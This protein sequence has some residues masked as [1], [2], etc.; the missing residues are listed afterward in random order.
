MISL[1][2]AHSRLYDSVLVATTEKESRLLFDYA[3]HVRVAVAGQV[4]E[5]YWD[6]GGFQGPVRVHQQVV[7]VVEAVGRVGRRRRHN[8]DLCHTTTAL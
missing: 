6:V 8:P 3:Q 5:V 7:V 4:T 2:V 1:D